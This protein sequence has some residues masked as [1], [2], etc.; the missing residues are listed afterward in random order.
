MRQHAV[1]VWKTVVS[2]TPRTLREIVDSLV[3]Q[4]I[5]SLVSGHEENTQVVGRCLGD[6]VGKLGDMVLPIIIC[7][8]GYK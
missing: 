5:T 4:I 2:A 7:I 3:G 6:V 8:W 1:H